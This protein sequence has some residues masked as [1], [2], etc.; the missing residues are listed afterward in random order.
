ME[1]TGMTELRLVFHECEHS[2]DL[3]MYAQDLTRS[4]ATI[5]NQRVDENT[6]V[7]VFTVEVESSTRFMTEFLKTTSFGFCGGINEVKVPR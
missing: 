1:E 6:E 5:V 4:G 7:G 3:A 2:G